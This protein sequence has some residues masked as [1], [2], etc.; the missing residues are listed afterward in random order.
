MQCYRKHVFTVTTLRVDKLETRLSPMK[1]SSLK[2]TVAFCL[3][4]GPILV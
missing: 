1:P 2:M 3:H 4:N